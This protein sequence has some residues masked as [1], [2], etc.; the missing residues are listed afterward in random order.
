MIFVDIREPERIAEMLKSMGI[1]TTRKKLEVADYVIMHYNYVVAVERK[2]ANDYVNS[3]VDG[4]F[5]DQVYNLV[6]SYELS[7][8]CVIGKPDFRRMKREAFI[9]SFLSIALKTKGSVIPLRI[10]NEKEFCLVLKFLNKQVENGRL[11]AFPMLRKSKIE[12]SVAMLTAIPGIGVEK[13]RRLLKRFGSV[14][15]VVNASISDL[16]RV[17]GIGEKQA[18]RIYD[19]VRGRKVR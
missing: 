2:D 5:F 14:Y 6:K 4:R 7:F 11:K 8:L 12:D 19:F 10:E 18:R 16:M 13:V 17:K 15:G 3:I 1:E 9:G